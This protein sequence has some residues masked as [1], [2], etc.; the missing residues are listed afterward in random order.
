MLPAPVKL[1]ELSAGHLRG[2]VLL[3]GAARISMCVPANRD[4]ELVNILTGG[5]VFQR[6]HWLY[7]SFPTSRKI[8]DFSTASPFWITHQ[9]AMKVRGPCPL[10]STSRVLGEAAEDGWRLW[11]HCGAPATPEWPGAHE[12]LLG[13]TRTVAARGAGGACPS[14]SRRTLVS[15]YGVGDPNL[16]CL[17]CCEKA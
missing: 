8:L 4:P 16:Q 2:K 17:R 3:G 10:S 1:N 5:S 15:S 14:A 6:R 12:R 13:G 7:M 9:E 11:G